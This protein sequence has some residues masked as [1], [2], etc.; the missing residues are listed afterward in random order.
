[1]GM[2]IHWYELAV[3]LLLKEFEGHIPVFVQGMGKNVVEEFKK[4]PAGILV[5]MESFG[6][7]IDIPGEQL[8]LIVIDKIPD[9]RRELVID[10]R[11][12]WYESSFGNEFQDYFLANRARALHQKCGRLL[13]REDDFGGVIIADQRIKKW[14]GHTLKQF[15]KL[16]EPYQVEVSTLDKACD[17]MRSF[18]VKD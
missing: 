18:L 13:R 8:Q 17:D 11:R 9:V 12:E 10:R 6:E 3:D 14:K 5:G 15:A 2:V 1:M 7:G 4:S 16:M